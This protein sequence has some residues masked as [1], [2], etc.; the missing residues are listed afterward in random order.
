MR[1]GVVAIDDAIEALSKQPPLPGGDERSSAAFQML[2]SRK[3]EIEASFGGAL[4]WQELPGRH[5]CRICTDLPG[6]WKSPEAD[7]PDM[8][9]RMIEALIRLENALRKPVQ[10]LNV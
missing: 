7:W 3:E 2:A 5:G 1:L 4:D 8:Q 10:E 6:G 9:D